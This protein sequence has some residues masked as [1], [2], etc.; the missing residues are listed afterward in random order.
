MRNLSQRVC[1]QK[2]A[3]KSLTLANCSPEEIPAELELPT[4]WRV[5]RWRLKAYGI[6]PCYGPL[7]L[8][9]PFLCHVALCAEQIME[10]SRVCCVAALSKR[11]SCNSQ[12]K[13]TS[14]LCQRENQQTNEIQP[15]KETFPTLLLRLHALGTHE[16]DISRMEKCARDGFCSKPD[17]DVDRYLCVSNRAE[18]YSLA[19]RHKKAA[20]RAFLCL[21]A[22]DWSPIRRERLEKEIPVCTSAF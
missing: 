9:A 16:K 13:R 11:L 17:L 10:T 15:S 21:P 12:S 19:V 7:A 18:I 3:E 6:V 2:G 8:W 5:S 4:A 20:K 22:E 14:S 1:I